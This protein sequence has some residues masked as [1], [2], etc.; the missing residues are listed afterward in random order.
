M[1]EPDPVGGDEKCVS[2]C[3][4]PGASQ[5]VRWRGG[6]KAQRIAQSADM[7]FPGETFKQH[8]VAAFALPAIGG[9]IAMKFPDKRLHLAWFGVES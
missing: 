6:R 7:Y 9:G 8:L 2:R 1:T 3:A 4:S 5:Q